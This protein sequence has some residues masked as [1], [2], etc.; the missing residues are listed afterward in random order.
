FDQIR[1]VDVDAIPSTTTTTLPTTTLPTTTTQPTAPTTPPPTTVAPTTLPATTTTIPTTTIPTTTIPTTTMP[2]TTIPT[3]TIPTTTVPTTTVPPPTTVPPTTVPPEGQPGLVNGSFESSS[4]W[5]INTFIRR[6]DGDGE[7]VRDGDW[8][9]RTTGS[10]CCAA[11]AV[12]DPV[13]VTPGRTYRLSG[14]VYRTSSNGQQYIDLGDVA[15]DPNLGRTSDVTDRWEYLQ[16]DWTAPAGTTSIRVR[17][18]SDR[19]TTSAPTGPAWFDQ[20]SLTPV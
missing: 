9:M 1:L 10:S 12:S 18:L 7:P 11:V 14:W 16:T 20:V 19:A 15:G 13:A 3:T 2:T 5:T 6:A 17:L 8:S 4:G